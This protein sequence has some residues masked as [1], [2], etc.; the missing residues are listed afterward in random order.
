MKN[1]LGIAVL[2]FLITPLAFVDAVYGLT[3]SA[4][5]ESTSSQ[6]FTRA[7]TATLSITGNLAL[8]MWVNLESLP[9]AFS[10]YHIISKRSGNTNRSWEFALQEQ[11]G[12]TDIQIVGVTSQ[13]GTNADQSVSISNNLS[14]ATGTWTHLAFSYNAGT[15]TISL[16][17][18]G[19]QLTYATQTT[20]ATA[21]FDNNAVIYVGA[22]DNAGTPGNFMD[23]RLSLGRVWS[24]TRT[25][26]DFATNM[27][28]VLGS[29]TNLAAEWTLDNTVNDNSGNTNT[30]TNVNSVTFGVDTP[31][32]CTP[33]V[34]QGTRAIIQGVQFLIRGTQVII[35]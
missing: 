23:G 20:N 22:T 15:G 25:A 34:V 10:A 28:N 33:V 2:L 19:V 5:L 24:T 17:Q 16:F 27:C 26:S 18:N 9:A 29:T 1:L 7:D 35:Q 13:D 21:I 14:I 6:Y 30:L 12:T 11:S 32:T 3:Q 8:E 31:P 4:D